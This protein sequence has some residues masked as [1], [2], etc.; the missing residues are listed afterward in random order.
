MTSEQRGKRRS[1]KRILAGWSVLTAA[2]VIL[3]GFADLDGPELDA[4]IAIH[5]AVTTFA[6]LAAVALFGLDGV[7][8]QII[9][10]W[11]GKS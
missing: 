9:P 5:Q 11:K 4:L 7:A 2:V 6:S 8:A 10:A 1:A 3:I